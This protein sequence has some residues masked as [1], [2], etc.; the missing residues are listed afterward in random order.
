MAGAEQKE[1]KAGTGAQLAKSAALHLMQ[2][3]GA[4]TVYLGAGF[5]FSMFA[6][7]EYPMIASYKVGTQ[8]LN[9]KS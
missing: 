8:H 9:R 2:V 5:N 7:R 6:R 1:P 3:L 4:A